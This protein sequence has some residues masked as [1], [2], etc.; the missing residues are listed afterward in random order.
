MPFSDMLLSAFFDSGFC[1][2]GMSICWMMCEHI[3]LCR[4]D[5]IA[6]EVC[7]RLA[8]LI[9]WSAN[10]VTVGDGCYI[11]ISFTAH[12][13]WKCCLILNILFLSMNGVNSESLWGEKTK[14]NTLPNREKGGRGGWKLSKLT[15]ALCC[16]C[17][18]ITSSSVMTT[19]CRAW[20]GTVYQMLCGYVA[21]CELLLIRIMLSAL[22]EPKWVQ[23]LVLKSWSSSEPSLMF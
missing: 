22:R 3:G 13:I 2:E 5:P 19:D 9:H 14:T 4:Q 8:K 21:Q 11:I 17:W 23:P 10:I 20:V 16:H 12:P 7:T 6:H 18:L 15:L 1:G